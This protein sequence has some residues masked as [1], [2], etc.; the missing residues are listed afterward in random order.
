MEGNLPTVS[1][2]SLHTLAGTKTPTNLSL[3]A[4]ILGAGPS[5]SLPDD[6]SAASDIPSGVLSNA[7]ERD[8]AAALVPI[9]GLPYTLVGKIGKRRVG[10]ERRYRMRTDC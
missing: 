3:R 1:P 9:G 10:K 4:S 6:S 2:C 5:V 7:S 8:S